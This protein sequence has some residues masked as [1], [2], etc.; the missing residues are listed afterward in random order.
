MNNFRVVEF[1]FLPLYKQWKEASL[2]KDERVENHSFSNDLLL[3]LNFTL[4]VLYHAKV[5]DLNGGVCN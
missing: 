2:L 5:T 3:A 1:F 4:A